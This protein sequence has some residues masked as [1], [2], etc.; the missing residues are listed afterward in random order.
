MRLGRSRRASALVHS[1]AESTSSSG[2]RG[3]R[4]E[5]AGGDG[6]GDSGESPRNRRR[7]RAAADGNAS[8]TEALEAPLDFVCEEDV[9]LAIQ[10]GEKLL[11][12]ERAIVTPSARDLAEEHRVLTLAP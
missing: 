8:A 4:G 12:S 2:S 10:A 5:G 7:N 1:P 11:V 6:V 9:R 3:F